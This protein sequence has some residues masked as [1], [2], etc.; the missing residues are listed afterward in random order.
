MRVEFPIHQIC[1]DNLRITLISCS[2]SQQARIM[3][4]VCAN[5][6]K[7]SLNKAIPSL[8]EDAIALA[9]VIAK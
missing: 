9:L 3:V 8:A 1:R 6:I 2:L 7:Y 4:V 5:A